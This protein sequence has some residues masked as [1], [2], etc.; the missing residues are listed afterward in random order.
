MGKGLTEGFGWIVGL[1]A[2]A[3]EAG[4]TRALS[5]GLGFCPQGGTVSA[6]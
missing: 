1:G 2:A 5:R 3:G 6:R 4:V